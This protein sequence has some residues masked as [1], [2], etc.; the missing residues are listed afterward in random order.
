M[1][2]LFDDINKIKFTLANITSIQD[3][4]NISALQN[5]GDDTNLF[6]II[7]SLKEFQTDIN[8]AKR[9]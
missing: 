3:K 7:D 2:E 8:S 4:I 6:E 1:P 9:E 5:I